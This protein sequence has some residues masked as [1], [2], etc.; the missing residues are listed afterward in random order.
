MSSNLITN[1]QQIP[2][3]PQ[4]VSKMGTT[5]PFALQ[6]ARNQIMGHSV[7]NINGYQPA[8]STTQIALWELAQAYVYPNSNVTMTLVSTS[9]SDTSAVKVT[10]NGLDSNYN[11]VSEVVALNGT[12]GVATVNTYFRINSLVLNAGNNVGTITAA[13]GGTTYAVILP[14]NG[15][16]QMA[17]YTVPAGYTFYLNRINAWSGT[18]L[19]T[20]NYVLYNLVTTVNGITSSAAQISFE[21]FV[22]VHRYAPNS[23]AAGTDIQFQFTSSSGAQHVAAYVEGYLVKNDD[24]TPPVVGV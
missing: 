9:A 15:R 8:I 12:T 24:Q 3:P 17:I 16:S 7:L 6:V 4:S 1:L 19:S 22:D 23:F 14:G 11:P 5:E 21:L 2:S 20:G 10:I 13:N 18:S